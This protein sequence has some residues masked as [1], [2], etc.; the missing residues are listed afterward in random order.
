MESMADWIYE[1]DPSRPVHYEGANAADYIYVDIVSPMYA[2]IDGLDAWCREMETEDPEDQKPMI[3]CEYS[4]AMGN[5]CGGL[6]EYWDLFRKERLLQG[7]FIWDWRDQGILRTQP[8]DRKAPAAVMALDK[9]RFV[10]ED[11]S[12]IHFAYGGDFGDQPNDGNFCMNGVVGADLVP[13]PH[14]IE[15]AYQYR[16]ILT[17]GAD[18]SAPQPVVSIFNENFFAPLRNQPM[19]W[20][21][22][23]N[24][25]PVKKGT[26]VIEELAPQAS[27]E[28]AIPVPDIQVNEGAEYHLNVAYPLARD[29]PWAGKDFVIASDQLALEWTQV[30]PQAYETS[31]GSVLSPRKSGD[32]LVFGSG[33]ITATIN[34]TNGQ[35][36]SYKKGRFEYLKQPLQLNFWRAPVDNDR[37]PNDQNRDKNMTAICTPWRGAGA[38][39]KV[40]NMTEQK[41]EGVYEIAFDLAVPV[42][43][44]KAK[45][46]YSFYG[47]GTLGVTLKLEPAGKDVP[48]AIPRVGFQCAISSSLSEWTWFGRGP[49]ENYSDRKTGTFVGLWKD[50]VRKLWFPYPYPQGT[51]NRTDVR[52]AAFVRGGHGLM[53]RPTDGQLLEMEAYPFLESD[54]EGTRHAADIPLRDLITVQISH[55]QMGVGGENSWGAWP[56]PDHVLATDRTYEYSFVLKPF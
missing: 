34:G 12:L 38:Q 30:V 4:H 27:V 41:K 31:E 48:G 7:G 47:D 29:F 10:T 21:L 32:N 54:L 33:D 25:K 5:S 23:E 40:T 8:L 24:G 16:S 2:K 9:E 13:N 50:D 46:T 52:Q 42:A 18:L 35:L 26:L 37:R 17:S 19:T 43:E 22:L 11:G 51:A 36:V 1:R 15:V 56:R 55:R 53:I 45:V 28:M 6:A 3:Q 44:T 20:T 14:A 49:E 39:A